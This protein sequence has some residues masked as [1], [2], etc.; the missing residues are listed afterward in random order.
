V[1]DPDYQI[2]LDCADPDAMA[3]F[4]AEALRYQLEGPPEGH[5]SWREYWLSVGVAIEDVEEG[6]DSIVDPAGLR[7]RV[8]FQQVPEAKSQKNR[9]HFDLRVGGGRGVAFAE[10]RAKVAAEADR[11]V[12][13][14]AT[15][16]GVFEEPEQGH[17]AIG[18]S[19]PEGNEFDVV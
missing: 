6:Y 3:R 9:M 5:S 16:R 12:G 7:P 10:R 17:F 19:D 8:W 2:T 13:L 1:K 11:L 15:V 18:M 4:W 14:G